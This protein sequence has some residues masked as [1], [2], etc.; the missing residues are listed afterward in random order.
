MSCNDFCQHYCKAKHFI[1]SLRNLFNGYHI[2]FALAGDSKLA[3]CRCDK[4][5]IFIKYYDT[6]NTINPKITLYELCSR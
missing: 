1:D 4:E 6:I 2:L 3:G 5:T